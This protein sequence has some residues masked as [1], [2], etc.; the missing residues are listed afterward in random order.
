MATQRKLM[1]LTGAPFLVELRDDGNSHHHQPVRHKNGTSE[2][3]SQPV[4]LHRGLYPGI[5]FQGK[6]TRL[7]A[8]TA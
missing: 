5:A 4:F 6:H 7:Y 1:D 8:R 3:G 2:R